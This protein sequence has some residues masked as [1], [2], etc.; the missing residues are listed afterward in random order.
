M[1]NQQ[2]LRNRRKDRLN[3]DADQR[4]ADIPAVFTE[5]R[6]NRIYDNVIVYAIASVFS[7]HSR[8]I[9]FAL[10]G[11]VIQAILAS[12]TQMLLIF[13]EE[14]TE[15][16]LFWLSGSLA[17]SS[18]DKLNFLLPVSLAGLLPETSPSEKRLPPRLRR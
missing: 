2:H 9:S 12:I 15:T 13:H 5:N 3:D 10:V 17:G 18:W 14:S 4:K 6:C 11:V 16:I 8:D 7:E 1:K